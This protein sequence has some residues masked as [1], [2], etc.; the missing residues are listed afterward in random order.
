ME[1]KFWSTESLDMQVS[2]VPERELETEGKARQS[3]RGSND[4]PRSIQPLSCHEEMNHLENLLQSGT[5]RFLRRDEVPNVT[6][7]SKYI[8]P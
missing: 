4:E 8:M 7:L 3:M 5:Y 2:G 6:I 1:A